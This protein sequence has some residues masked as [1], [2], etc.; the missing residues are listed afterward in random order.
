[1]NW[2]P[3]FLITILAFIT[4]SSTAQ[5]LDLSE[6]TDEWLLY[7]NGYLILTDS[8]DSTWFKGN[9][10]CLDNN[11]PQDVWCE[12]NLK[13]IPTKYQQFLGQELELITR[14]NTNHII[15]IKRLIIYGSTSPSDAVA[16]E[17]YPNFGNE[18][19][20]EKSSHTPEETAQFFF[21]LANKSN[22]LYL[23]AEFDENINTHNDGIG[24][25][26]R[27]L[28]DKN[29]KLLDEIFPNTSKIKETQTNIFSNFK[30]YLGP[31]L[32][33]KYLQER[34]CYGKKS[35]YWW[36]HPDI[37][38][39]WHFFANTSGNL[40]ISLK[41]ALV[42]GCTCQTLSITSIWELKTEGPKLVWKTQDRIKVVDVLNYQKDNSYQFIIEAE[43]PNDGPDLRKL[44]KKEKW[45]EEVIFDIP[46]LGCGC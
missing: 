42:D 26:F 11:N 21:E 24:Y 19:E 38:K 14:G 29:V 10:K 28:Q 33:K 25:A 2:K 1:M 35:Y 5:I 46:F 17:W 31:A 41:I 23:V 45:I 36:D 9:P 15:K 39:E 13:Y 43:T 34:D 40:F 8:I 27:R 16:Q 7:K 6:H 22:G 30:K 20:S 4:C 44:I 37:E 12:V 18:N 32:Q 3:N